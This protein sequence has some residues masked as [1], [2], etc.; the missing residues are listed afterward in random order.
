M[1]KTNRLQLEEIIAKNYS[2]IGGIVIKKEGTVLYEQYF[3]E[4]NVNSRFHVYSVAKS[5]LSLLFG[6]ALDQGYIKSLDQK[7]IEFFPDYPLKPKDN[8]LKKI[9]IRDMLTMTVPFK[10]VIPPFSYIK[11]FTSKDWLSFSL[12]QIDRKGTLGEF[13]Y[14]ALIGPDILSGILAAAT[15]QP[16]LKYAQQ[17]LFQ[18]L[19]I[20]VEKSVTFHSAKEQKDFNASTTIS[21]WV[22]DETGLNT[23]GWGLTL[24]ANDM[25]KIGQL[26]LNDGLWNE[27]Q[28]VSAGWLKQSLTEHS[29]W[30][31]MGFSYGYLWWI[32]DKDQE[33]Y[34]AMGDS[35]NV[36]YFNKKKN[37][38]I[39]IASLSMQ[40]A[41]DRL[42][43]IH[44]HI[45]PLI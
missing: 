13:Q 1:N 25:A 19:D 32:I 18:P 20:T 28:I 3:N 30:K 42:E 6:I 5:V 21:G 31:E 2:N 11:Y 15:Q 4:C 9:T 35:G 12:N 39:S 7:M 45:L 38:V 37:I 24:S 36:I 33:S 34:A 40:N 23:G 29:Q 16:V 22:A 14:A 17:N 41:K 10:K 43:L 27:K 8:L 44:Q 26:Y